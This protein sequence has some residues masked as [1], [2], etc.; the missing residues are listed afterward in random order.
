MAC[1]STCK[2]DAGGDICKFIVLAIIFVA[3]NEREKFELGTYSVRQWYTE[4]TVL[5]Y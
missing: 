4:S 3:T 5:R 2:Y 1:T